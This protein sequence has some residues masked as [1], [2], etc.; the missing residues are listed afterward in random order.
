MIA[1][2]NYYE[3]QVLRNDGSLLGVDSIEKALWDIVADSKRGDGAGVG[4]LSSDDRDTWTKVCSLSAFFFP[5]ISA[6]G[7]SLIHFFVA[8]CQR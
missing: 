2:D 4:V 6:L 5:T 1:R 8:W 7:H 3:L